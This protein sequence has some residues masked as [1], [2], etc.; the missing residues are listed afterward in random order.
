VKYRES[1][2]P[3]APA[4]ALEDLAEVFD[5]PEGTAVRY[6]EK[7]LHVRDAWKDRIPAVVHADGTGRLQTVSADEEPLFHALLK[8]HAQKTGAPCLLN[9]SFNLNGEPVVNSPDDALRTFVTCGMDAMVLG[10][11]VVEKDRE[12]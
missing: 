9:T 3:F 10:S 1:Y 6:M 11:Y 2:R 12:G 4:V 8:S 7:A 5:A